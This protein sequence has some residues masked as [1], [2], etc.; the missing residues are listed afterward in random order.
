MSR[1]RHQKFLKFLR[2]LDGHFPGAVTR[3]LILDN[4]GT[5]GLCY[6]SFAR[7]HVPTL[8]LLLGTIN[9]ALLPELQRYR[10][11][12]ALLLLSETIFKKS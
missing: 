2:R 5:R 6:N 8:N 10:Q 3:H 7:N 4:Y 1:H 11:V 9:L 12:A